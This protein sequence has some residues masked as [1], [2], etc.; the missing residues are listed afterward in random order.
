MG[1]IAEWV[2]M[3][4]LTVVIP[5]GLNHRALA[6]RA[7]ASVRQQTATCKLLTMLDADKRGPGYLRNVMLRQVDTEFVSFLDADDWIEPTFAAE[8]VAEY[9]RIGGDRYIYTDWVDDRGRIVQTPCLNGPD[10]Y[11]LSVPDRRPYCGGTWHVITTLLPTA[12]V[13][14]VGGFDETLPAVEDTEFYLKLCTTMRCGHRLPRPLFHYAP[15]GGR[16]IEFR[17]GPDYDRVM[18]ELTVRF[19]GRMGCCGSD[20]RV[21]IP[22]GVRQP[23]DVLAMA[24][25][26]GNRQEH[27]RVTG[28]IYPRI[29]IPRTAWVDPRDAGHNPELWKV[30]E[31]PV[32]PARVDE[33]QG[34]RSLEQIALAGMATVKRNP[35]APPG[36]EPAPP[37][38]SARPD[39]SRVIRLTQQAHG[40]GQA[41]ADRPA[42]AAATGDPIFVFPEKDYPSYTD[43]RRLVILAG[44]KTVP[45]TRINAWSRDPYIVVTPE[46]L[47]DLRM[48]ARVICWQFE[49]AGD[50]ARNYDGFE[51]EVWA[52]DK[53]W[54]DAHGAKYVMLGSHPDLVG[55]WLRSKRMDWLYDVTLLGYMTPRREIVKQA[56]ADQ[57]WP[58]D[59]PGHDG[60]TRADVLW[61][62]RLMLNVHQHDNAPY[63]APQ[64]IALAA[65]YGLPVLSETLA[66]PGDLRH[67]AFADYAALPG[68]TRRF[69]ET[70]NGQ[71][72]GAS[73]H[74]YLCL[75]RPF[76]RCVEEALT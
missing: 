64:R 39:V 73:L 18:R 46:A 42:P 36:F 66:D 34:L 30:I 75:E 32:T 52:S 62:T 72:L 49:Y 69:L 56:L 50:Y 19:G 29:S 17:N 45:I 28:R 31:R 58:V 23:D 1:G 20:E 21:A 5:V 24:L 55:E 15:G 63:I 47:P 61:S 33:G 25:W 41:S 71:A 40:N 76:R 57:R 74:E 59:Y 53:A 7:I 3:V 8:T 37:P 6:E 4:E 2:D 14:A 44:F 16:A 65:A 43:L 10:G 9:R 26:R 60:Q 35:Y 51:D 22:I 27:G 11:P 38:V 54:A 70:Q 68:A 13:R 48:R 67:V 12:W